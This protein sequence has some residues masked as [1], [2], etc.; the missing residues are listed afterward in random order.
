MQTAAIEA[1]K[2]YFDESVWGDA[3]TMGHTHMTAHVIM[4]LSG[5]SGGGASGPASSMSMGPVSITYALP[6]AVT[7]SLFGSTPAGRA[8]LALRESLGSMMAPIYRIG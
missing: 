1:A 5:A 4:G 6:A 2:A 7:T 8:F 3:L